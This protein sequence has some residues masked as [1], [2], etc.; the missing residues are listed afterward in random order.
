MPCPRAGRTLEFL[1][2][3]QSNPT[4]F[5]DRHIGA[6]RLADIDTCLKRK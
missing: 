6:R 1:M 3:I 4:V 2:T 5:A